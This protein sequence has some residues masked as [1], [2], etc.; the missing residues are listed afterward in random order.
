MTLAELSPAANHVWQSTLFATVAWAVAHS[1]RQHG[2]Q[3]RYSI[4]LAASLKFLVP[5]SLLVTAGSFFHWNQAP[6]VSVPVAHTIRQFGQPFE[7]E[8]LMLAVTARTA[9]QTSPDFGLALT[10][11]WILGAVCLLI[12]R[13]VRWNRIRGAVKAAVP[14]NIAGPVPVLSSPA[15]IEP[16]V[17][18]ILRP[19]LL[20]P[21]GISERLAPAELQSILAHEFCH[22]RRR[23]NLTAALHMVVGTV[24]W[25]HPLVWWIGSR[26]VAERENCCDAEVLS[27]GNEPEVYA[28]GLLN[29]CRHYLESPLV[30]ASGV[31]GADLLKR[32]EA[33]M[34][35]RGV[36][37]L[38]FSR[39]ILLG[40]A[41]A[42]A[43]A[44]PLLI[45]ALSV[46]AG[47]AQSS[48]DSAS[49]EV[50]S[51]KPS[52]PDA[53]GIRLGLLPGGGLRCQNVR[54]RQLIEFA[55]EVQPFQISGGPDWLNSRGFDIVAKA[56]QSGDAPELENLNLEQQKSLEMLVRERTRSLLAERFQLTLHR[57]SK[58]M[59]VYALV[60]VK[61]GAKLKPAGSEEG[62]R[63]QMRGRPGQLTAEN[64]GL[65]GLANHL[66]RLLSRP[67]LD[68][69]GL[70]G[71]FN[72]QLEWTPDNE[73]EGG[74]RGPG[75]AEKASAIGAADPT[76]PSLFTALQEQLGLK[77]ESTK[78]PG[79][80]VVI[81]RA[82]KPSEN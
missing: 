80:M 76:G 4:W 9:P 47:R 77:L 22:V 10:A 20:L 68:R 3:L 1:L 45:G 24:F 72:F 53:R 6:P 48:S 39:K 51:I 29:V 67:V 14:L 2:P 82:E 30:C 52:D 18:G 36:N 19:V 42:T 11:V 75:K 59:P 5:F 25:F 63:Q 50:A 23:D 71:R 60:T 7:P 65:D 33:I 15:R 40:M 57:T 49:F 37:R 44:G 27:T 28:S 26:L 38:S 56:P 35:H 17:F 64:M 41:G 81:D 16:G 78:G 70:T 8:P 58:E 32:V 62:N 61:G 79:E 73:L 13:G 74:P 43:V 12:Q 66:S 55:Y 31:T 69:T 34:M 21:N 54:L 46:P